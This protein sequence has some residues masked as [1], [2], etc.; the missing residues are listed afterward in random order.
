MG[1]LIPVF[2]APIFSAVVGGLVGALIPTLPSVQP[3]RPWTDLNI[4]ERA[5]VACGSG[6]VGNWTTTLLAWKWGL[7]WPRH[8]PEKKG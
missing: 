1:I 5:A 4:I 6:F 2:L 8:S 3:F 7:I